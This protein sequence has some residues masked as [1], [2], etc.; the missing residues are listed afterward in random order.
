MLRYWKSL[1]EVHG[2]LDVLTF[3][4]KIS[5]LEWRANNA[6]RRLGLENVHIPRCPFAR[7]VEIPQELVRKSWQSFSPPLEWG[8]GAA[9]Q[10]I[11]MVVA[12]ILQNAWYS[13][14]PLDYVGKLTPVLWV[15]R[16][17]LPKARRPAWLKDEHSV[18]LWGMD[19]TLSLDNKQEDDVCWSHGNSTDRNPWWQWDV[20][21]ARKLLLR[22]SATELSAEG[23][24]NE[25]VV[26][27]SA[28]THSFW[29]GEWVMRPVICHRW[30]KQRG[31]FPHLELSAVP[32]YRA[33]DVKTALE[34]IA[35]S[36]L[37][38]SLLSAITD[39]SAYTE[40]MIR[41]ARRRLGFPKPETR[42]RQSGRSPILMNKIETVIQREGMTKYRA[43]KMLGIPR[44]TLYDYLKGSSQSE[45]SGNDES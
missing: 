18:S 24:T 36:H 19:P 14:H 20:I 17:Q 7:F 38:I 41:N 4:G 34:A 16:D 26:G 25:A 23:A 30:S 6:L 40:G 2:L 10:R 32:F 9:P 13:L 1:P 11:L 29:E 15:R 28:K 12:P 39:K 33:K 43:A 35:Q 37:C 31:S 8:D 21:R 27:S 45:D 44:S 22:L 5:D 42:G 3:A